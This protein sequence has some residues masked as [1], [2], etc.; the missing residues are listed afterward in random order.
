VLNVVCAF[1]LLRSMPLVPVL[2][3]LLPGQPA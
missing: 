1:L 3:V 2:C